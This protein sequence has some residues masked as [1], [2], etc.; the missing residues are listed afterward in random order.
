M[1]NR[2]DNIT[3]QTGM[4]GAIETMLLE[5]LRRTREG[6]E[7]VLET[8]ASLDKAISIIA[9]EH[10]HSRLEI[11]ALNEKVAQLEKW[12]NEQRG[13]HGALG[14]L[15]NSPVVGW[16]VAAGAFVWYRLSPPTG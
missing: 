12:K 8:L 2:P 15:V 9:A 7:K 14:W 5:E 3:I 4:A 10:A 13:A 16:V 6:N 11:A 1:T